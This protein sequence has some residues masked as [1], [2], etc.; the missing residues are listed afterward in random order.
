MRRLVLLSL[1]SG[2][3]WAQAPTIT[4][5]TNGVP[6]DNLYG[7]GTFL[8]ILGTFSTPTAGRDY[9][10]TVGGATSG[11]NVAANGVFIA[12]TIPANAAA[13]STTLVITYQG[14]ASNALPITIAPLAPEMQGTGYTIAGP[15]KPPVI[16]FV[17]FHHNS[18]SQSVT[19]VSPA[20]PGEV[21]QTLVTGLG[22]S[23]APGV[24]P[25]VTVDGMNAQVLQVNAGSGSETIYFAVPNNAP[26][27]IDPVVV[28]VG[29][30]ASL[31]QSLPVGTAPAIGSVLNGA[32]FG[33]SGVVAAG[34]IVS[35]FGANFGSQTNASAF[36]STTVDGVSVLFGSTAAPIFALV[37]TGGQINVLVPT[38]L[39]SSG[40][41]NVS[42]Q[43]ANG[44]SP[45]LA[46]TLAPA[47]PGIFYYGD[48]LVLA[49]HNAVAV[50]ANTAWIAMPASMAASYGLPTNCTALGAASLC[51][52]PAA[53][54]GYLQIYVTGL[55][56]ATPN[57]DPNGTVLPTGTLAPLSG[58]P[59]YS[60]VAAA[61][62]TIG[63]QPAPVLFSGIAPGYNGLYVVDVQIPS[64]ITPGS[65]VPLVISIAG[66]SDATTTV[67][68]Q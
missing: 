16:S 23:V 30:V 59:L 18:N 9:T 49:R 3:A 60:T 24:A 13:G 11:I 54:G 57:G 43:T 12:A 58:S 67:A 68:I 63:G 51:A 8:I 33:S 53:R 25:T 42:V 38:E 32:S 2:T 66:A 61:T 10:I 50:T 56:K 22:S 20:A 55:G 48:P 34:S 31:P 46:L 64:N 41:V 35:L 28:T 26:V 19:P 62:A 52:Q 21:I 47:A 27:G 15:Q 65:D 36:P 1:L 44:T 45:P 39:G 40:T 7:P 4:N 5:F 37:G 17:P 6:G 29:G 14:Q